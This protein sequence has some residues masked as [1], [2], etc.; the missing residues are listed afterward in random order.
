MRFAP[1]QGFTYTRAIHEG[2]TEPQRKESLRARRRAFMAPAVGGQRPQRRQQGTGWQRGRRRCALCDESQPKRPPLCKSAIVEFLDFDATE[3]RK[4]CACKQSRQTGF[5][6]THDVLA[7]VQT[8]FDAPVPRESIERRHA[9][10]EHTAFAQGTAELLEDSDRIGHVLE[11][12]MEEAEVKAVVLRRRVDT[13]VAD[14]RHIRR[15]LEAIRIPAQVLEPV[16]VHTAAA[17]VIQD[18]C[19]LGRLKHR[20]V[21][22][23]RIEQQLGLRTKSGRLRLRRSSMKLFELPCLE[24]ADALSP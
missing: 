10:V 4:A 18:L 11:H 15:G 22:S 16:E 20:D 1:P 19:S 9:D 24:L 23:E 5:G 17:S 21:R 6:E 2:R 7:T 3:R 8:V 14:E 12:M 13:M